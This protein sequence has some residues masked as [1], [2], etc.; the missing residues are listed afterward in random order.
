MDVM[1]ILMH[2]L[3]GIPENVCKGLGAICD[4]NYASK[5]NFD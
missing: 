4:E 1:I 3:L 2:E 5:E